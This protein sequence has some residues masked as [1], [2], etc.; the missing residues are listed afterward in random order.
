MLLDQLIPFFFVALA[1]LGLVQSSM[2]FGILR[3]EFHSIGE[4]FLGLAAISTIKLDDSL[5][6]VDIRSVIVA[7]S[8]EK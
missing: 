7:D 1:S 4:V 5:E 8:A 2:A 3:V 6:I